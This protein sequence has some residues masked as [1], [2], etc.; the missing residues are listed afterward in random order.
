MREGGE[1][2]EA[3]AG[4]IMGCSCDR[5]LSPSLKSCRAGVVLQN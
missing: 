1:Q 3:E 5:V 4:V 2:D